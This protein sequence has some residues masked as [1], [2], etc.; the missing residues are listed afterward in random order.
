MVR[1]EVMLLSESDVLI[2]TKSRSGFASHRISSR[3]NTVTMGWGSVDER[4]LN[5]INVPSLFNDGVMM[6]L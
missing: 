1:Y 4:E 5:V 2:V 3:V 6:S